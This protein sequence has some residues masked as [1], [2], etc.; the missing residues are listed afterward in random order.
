MPATGGGEKVL[1][2]AR[3][4]ALTSANG[5]AHRLEN[6]TGAD[7]VLLEIGDRPGGDEVS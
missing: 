5:P 3:A 7:V 2:S 1:P 4:S 6:R